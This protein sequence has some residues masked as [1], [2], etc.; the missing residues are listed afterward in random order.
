[1]PETAG[2]TAFFCPSTIAVHNEGNMAREAIQFRGS[3]P[4]SLA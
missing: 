1:M 4:F 3:L 2:K